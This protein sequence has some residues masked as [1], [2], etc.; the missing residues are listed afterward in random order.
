MFLYYRLYNHF[1]VKT[2]IIQK[3]D[4]HGPTARKPYQK[5]STFL[6]RPL[7]SY[8][9]ALAYPILARLEV[10]VKNQM[11]NRKAIS[12]TFLIV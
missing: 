8:V 5:I 2:N 10:S 6:A 4:T 9:R 1:W 7:T 3:V 11:L 12:T